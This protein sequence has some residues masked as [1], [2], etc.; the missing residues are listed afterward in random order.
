MAG[1]KGKQTYATEYDHHNA[2]L[3]LFDGLHSSNEIAQR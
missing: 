1:E 2:A 3:A